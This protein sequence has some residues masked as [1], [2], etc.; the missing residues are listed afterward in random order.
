MD[1]WSSPV[2]SSSFL[3]LCMG[4][5]GPF[6]Y[7]K[8]QGFSGRDVHVIHWTEQT[9]PAL[10]DTLIQRL[11]VASSTRGRL[12]KQWYEPA[13]LRHLPF[14]QVSSFSHSSRSATIGVQHKSYTSKW[15][16]WPLSSF[17][18]RTPS[19][20][21][22]STHRI[23]SNTSLSRPYFFFNKTTIPW[24][25]GPASASRSKKQPS[26]QYTQACWSQ[27][28]NRCGKSTYILARCSHR[29]RS[30]RLQG[31]TFHT[32]QHLQWQFQVFVCFLLSIPLFLACLDQNVSYF[33]L[34]LFFYDDFMGCFTTCFLKN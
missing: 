17:R 9:S 5:T 34:V 23:A 10:L 4:K 31:R 8:S 3:S 14:A 28:N 32:H 29:V 27:R 22:L 19:P 13:V 15:G 6:K 2:Q 25:D 26:H 30:G 24:N 11:R 20:P 16:N 18:Q 12:Q 7:L 1:H 33:T 21:P